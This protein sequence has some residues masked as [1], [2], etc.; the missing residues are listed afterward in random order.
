MSKARVLRIEAE[1]GN[2]MEQYVSKTEKS[3][4]IFF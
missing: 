1:S 3:L 2:E 4:L